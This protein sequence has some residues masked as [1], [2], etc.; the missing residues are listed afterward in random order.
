MFDRRPQFQRYRDRLKE[1][2]YASK[3]VKTEYIDPDKNPAAAQQNKCSSTARS[4]STTRAAPSGSPPTPSRTSPTR[5]IK[6]VTGQQKK[7]YFT[8]G[9]GERDTDVD[10]TRRLQHD[11][12]ALGRENYATDKLVLAQKGAVPDDA[13]VLVIAGPED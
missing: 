2:Q 10:R 3:Q 12:Q 4:S 5:I 11:R 6:V 9:H 1:Y 13:T 7:V 8:Q